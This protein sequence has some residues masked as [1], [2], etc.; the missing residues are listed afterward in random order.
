AGK[1]DGKPDEDSLLNMDDVIGHLD[2][3]DSVINMGVTHSQLFLAGTILQG[4]G[5]SGEDD[6]ERRRRRAAQAQGAVMM[7]DPTQL[8]NDFRNFG[9]ISLDFLPDPIKQIFATTDD[10]GNK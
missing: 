5:L 2:A 7:L 3:F 10:Q 6:E 1:V 4:L 8:E 9:T